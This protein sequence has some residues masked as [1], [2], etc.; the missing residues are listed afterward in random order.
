MCGVAGVLGPEA[1]EIVSGLLGKMSH[2][3]PD[4]AG[5]VRGEGV[6]VGAVR[7][8]MRGDPRQRPPNAFADLVVAYNGEIYRSGI[9][10]SNPPKNA[11]DEILAILEASGRRQDADGMFAVVMMPLRD[12]A[13]CVRRDRLGIKP[14]YYLRRDDTQAVASEAEAL[15]LQFGV[16]L[17]NHGLAQTM[18]LGRAIG[19]RT[20][21]RGVRE[22]VGGGGVRISSSGRQCVVNERSSPVLS[23]DLS[24]QLRL[25]LVATLQG[26]A[27]TSRKL[28]LAV[29]GGLDSTILA[30]E[31]NRLGVE[32]LTTFSVIAQDGGDGVESLAELGM[33]SNGAWTRWRHVV[34]RVNAN[35]F[36]QITRESVVAMGQPHR[37][38]SAPLTVAL[39][40]AVAAEEVV[41]L[42]S[43]EGPDELFFGYAGHVDLAAALSYAERVSARRRLLAD[44]VFSRRMTQ[45][46]TQQSAQR[47]W[48]ALEEHLGKVAA[49]TDA[50]A[51]MRLELDFSLAPLLQRNDH[52]FMRHSVEVRVPFLHGDCLAIAEADAAAQ[53]LSTLVGK[54]RLRDAWRNVLRPELVAREKTPFR[55]PFA[56]WTKR[57]AFRQ[58]CIATIL[59]ATGTTVFRDAGLAPPTAQELMEIDASSLFAW[60]TTATWIMH[61]QATYYSNP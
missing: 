45:A 53:P 3:G 59:E 19:G 26:C 56:V 34:V 21:Y 15:A 43:G 18:L 16:H 35:D 23:A 29:S 6:S 24:E 39:A 20:L 27:F 60:V 25:S 30:H 2:R 51:L 10:D 52:I 11:D 54:A 33:P 5:A 17:D 41:A 28:G 12:Q 61:R 22:I 49:L 14:L 9:D 8:A 31:L 7:L 32:D 1:H 36:L 48:S 47:V 38:T 42:L 37:L 46:L 13:L 58:S 40:R 50:Q 4:G 44:Y 55:A 57:N